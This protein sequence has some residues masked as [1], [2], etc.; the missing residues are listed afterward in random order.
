MIVR[1]LPYCTRFTTHGRRGEYSCY[2]RYLKAILHTMIEALRALAAERERLE[3]PGVE[4][5]AL[6]LDETHALGMT[7][8]ALAAAPREGFGPETSTIVSAK[9]LESSTFPCVRPDGCYTPRSCKAD[10][11]CLY[12]D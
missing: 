7:L 3:A 10:R 1:S 2:H 6:G 12:K 5:P 11:K 9:H 4:R 8:L